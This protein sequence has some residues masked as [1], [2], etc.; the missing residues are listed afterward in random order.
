[1][2][3]DAWGFVYPIINQDLCVDCEL[4]REVCPINAP[5][6]KN[7]PQK[8]YAVYSLD[9]EDRLTSTSG[10]AASAFANYVLSRRGVVYGCCGDDIYKVQHIRID[11]IEDINRLKNSKYVQSEIANLYRLIKVDVIKNKNLTLFIGTPCQVAGLRT[12]LRRDYDNLI[13]VDLV[14]HGVPSQQLLADGLAKYENEYSFDKVLFR[15]KDLIKKSHFFGLF[16]FQGNEEISSQLYPQDNYITGFITGLFYR[17]SCYSCQFACPERC[18][19]ITLGDFWGLGACGETAIN[20][21]LGVSEVLL[22]TEKGIRF[23][24]DSKGCLFIEERKTEEAISGNG[25]LMR[26][27]VR[28][29]NNKLFRKLYIENGFEKACNICLKRTRVLY[30][31][32]SLKPAVK[33]ILFSIPFIKAIYYKKKNLKK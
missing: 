22:N 29:K 24:N 4:C 15:K 21:N 11:S 9:S 32:R 7:Y 19:D 17:D 20:E 5:V 1:M 23:F 3:P 14:C 18:S 8:T 30:K 33:R 26:P 6:F 25:Q 13:L 28:H 16:L 10:G 27:S 2:R 12:Y 31:F